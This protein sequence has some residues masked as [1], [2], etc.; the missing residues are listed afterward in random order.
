MSPFPKVLRTQ[1]GSKP[2]TNTQKSTL[3][4]SCSVFQ[5]LTVFI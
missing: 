4:Y 3:I 5:L 2:R 1:K